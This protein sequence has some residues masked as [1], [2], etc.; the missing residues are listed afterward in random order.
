MWPAGITGPAWGNGPVGG[1][2]GIGPDFMTHPANA[3]RIFISAA[4]Q[5]ADEHA[6]AL[7]DAFH[8]LAPD[9][10]FAGL[11]GPAM[12]AA[13]CVCF[14]DMTARSAMA[15]A[16]FSRVPE[17]WR[18]LRRLKEYVRAERFDATVVVDSPALHLPVARLCRRAGTPV[19]Y[20]IAPQTWA[21]GWKRLRN[22][23]LRSRVD[24][25]ACIW[26]FEEAYFRDAG[27]AATYVG[28]PS[29]DRISEHESSEEE[30]A[31]LRQDASPVIALLPG[32]RA[33]VI[34]EVFPGQLAVAA[35]VAM[36]YRK[37]KFLAVAAAEDVRPLIRGYISQSGKALSIDT[38][39]GAHQRAAALRAAD[40]ALVASGTVT[41]EVAYRGTPMIVM[42]NSSPWAYHLVGRWLITTPH[43][44]IPNILAGR[45][46]VPEF[47]PYY[48]SVD[49]IIATAVEWL[50]TP[51][52]LEKVRRDLRAAVAPIARPGAADRTAVLL[53]ELAARNSSCP[54]TIGP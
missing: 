51:G 6:A 43:F 21:W 41:L 36:R 39:C 34:R 44:S 2:S 16:A 23:R 33:H 46:I 1:F 20:Y 49:P 37:A 32:S 45:R 4:E 42:Y 9:A 7:I 24:R 54:Q 25:L 31:A 35:A 28:H 53:Q 12:R 14:H 10:V 15:L 18:L 30:A 26:P 13:G 52:K 27:I 5:S 8:R 29:F 48:R 11:A 19:L 17:A 40:L 22:R 3:P 47:M 38:L 50:S